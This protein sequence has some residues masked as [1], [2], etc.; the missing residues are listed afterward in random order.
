MGSM[1]LDMC[2]KVVHKGAPMP[3]RDGLDYERDY[4]CIVLLTEDSQEG[5]K[6]FLEK[7]KPLFVG[8]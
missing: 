8:R 4:F 5:T 2:K 1:G 6:A 7:R 3:L